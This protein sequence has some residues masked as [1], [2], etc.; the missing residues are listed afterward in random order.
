MAR[1]TFGRPNRSARWARD[2]SCQVNCTNN[3]HQASHR[4]KSG[5][6]SLR[7]AADSE[8]APRMRLVTDMAAFHRDDAGTLTAV[9]ARS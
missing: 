6:V 2:N 1:G 4:L 7:G 3:V 5:I 9:T 8:F